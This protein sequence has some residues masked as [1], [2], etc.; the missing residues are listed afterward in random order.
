MRY[1]SRSLKPAGENCSASEPE[2]TGIVWVFLTLN[3]YLQFENFLLHTDHHA[4]KWLPNIT[5]TPSR[6]IRWRFWLA[7]FD[8]KVWYKNWKGKQ[9]AE[10]L[11]R[12]LTGSPTVPD[13]EDEISSF[14]LEEINDDLNLE[15]IKLNATVESIEIGFDGDDQLLAIEERKEARLDQI[16]PEELLGS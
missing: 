9:H 5:N 10:F 1:W 11:S 7:E 2:W 15:N 13:D 14:P 16:T 12:L 4:L 6:L 3:P 8:F